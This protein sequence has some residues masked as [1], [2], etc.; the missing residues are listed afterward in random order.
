VPTDKGTEDDSAL[1][2]IAT[3]CGAP[4]ELVGLLASDAGEDGVAHCTSVARGAGQIGRALGM[5]SSEVR[6]LSL[7]GLLHDVGKSQ[8][9]AEVLDKAGPLD[10]A[11]WAQI[12][13]HP[14]NGAELVRANGAPEVAA[15]I[16]AH[17]ERPD[18]QGYPFGLRGAQIPLQA[19]I[20]AVVDTFDAMT[21]RRPYRE[22]FSARQAVDELI[23]CGG[24]QLDAGVVR[25]FC[26]LGPRLIFGAD[27]DRRRWEHLRARLSP[28]VAYAPLPAV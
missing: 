15:W 23:H 5:S 11:E 22:A 1:R 9:P 13:R 27:P 8:I 6:V 2:E 17:H 28:A 21:S 18:G 19:R 20:L 3:D 25:T 10:D 12:R 7:A 16:L 26:R 24:S 14:E 4:L